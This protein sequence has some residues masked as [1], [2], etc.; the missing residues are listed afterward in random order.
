MQVFDYLLTYL[1]TCLLTKHVGR[2]AGAGSGEY[3]RS[4]V[5]RRNDQSTGA[6]EAEILPCSL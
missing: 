4:V 5:K 2:E 3:G 6:V 1:I